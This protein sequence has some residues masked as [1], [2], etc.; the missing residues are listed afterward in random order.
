MTTL[1]TEAGEPFQQAE[2]G[3]PEVMRGSARPQKDEQRC[4]A[5]LHAARGRAIVHKTFETTLIGW[6]MWMLGQIGK[7]LIAPI[8]S[9]CAK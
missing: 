6:G 7:T 9:S 2:A 3:K 5:R 8:G 4:N 1:R